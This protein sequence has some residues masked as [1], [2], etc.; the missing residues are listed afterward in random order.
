MYFK[1]TITILCSLIVSISC[2]GY[3]EQKTLKEIEKN[4]V[5]LPVMPIKIYRL[6]NETVREI[7]AYNVGVPAQTDAS[8]CIGAS[9]ENLCSLIAQGE[10]ICAANFVPLGAK[11]YI[12]NYG[13]CIV[14]DRMN[15][16]YHNR[17]DIAF[18]ADKIKEAKRFGIKLWNVYYVVKK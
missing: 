11:L 16:R 7:T 5:V 2:I 8:P 1:K 18:P 3:S 4:T 12:E 9:G 17:V 13:I 15:S 6:K 14:K 10:K